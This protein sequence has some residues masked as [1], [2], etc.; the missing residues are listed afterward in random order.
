VKLLNEIVAILSDEHGSLNGALLKTKVLL[1]KIGQQQ[2]VEWVNDELNGYGDR[3][4]VPEYRKVR[5]AVYGQVQAGFT[6]HNRIPLPI[7]HL[8]E[9]QREWLSERPM[10]QAVGALEQLA[11]SKS[12]TLSSNVAPETYGLFV[13]AFSAEVG[14]L[15]AWTE[16]STTQMTQ[17]LIEV[18]SRLLEFA[19][20][21]QSEMGEDVADDDVKRAVESIDTVGMFKDAVFGDGTVILVGNHNRQQVIN[22]VTQ[23]D[24]GAL[25]DTLKKSGVTDEDVLHLKSAI[26]ADSKAPEL[27]EKKFGPA[28]RGWMQKMMSK[29]VD[30]SW[31]IELGV[32]GGLLT[33]ALKAYYF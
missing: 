8:N 16:F 13:D 4:P 30:A 11:D 32:A 23:G 15:R 7:G 14:I 17:I 9:E 31:Q 33:E 5:T 25:A 24:F 10:R 27:Q 18:R 28:V 26:D 22:S 12:G 2:L 6:I 29:A 21:L 1:H 19:L 3:K 20:S